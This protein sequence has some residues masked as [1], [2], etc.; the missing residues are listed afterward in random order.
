ME[1]L[2]NIV[3]KNLVKLRQNA[4]LTQLEL[5]NKIQ[6]SDKSVSKWER[7]ES[8]PDLEVLVKLSKIYDVN[9]N[10]FIEKDEKKI[11]PK[12]L[13]KNSHT[14][15][16]LLSAGLVFFIA[17][18]VFAVLFMIPSTKSISWIMFVYATPISAIAL[19]ALSIKWKNYLL[20]AIYTSIILW[21]LIISICISI[22][23]ADIWSLCVIGF[24][25]EFLIIFWFILRKIN[26][27]QK[28]TNIKNSIIKKTDK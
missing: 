10:T 20:Q 17:S 3:S 5:A 14:M 19:L 25:F 13:I 1:E 21:G 11:I 9:L 26:F 18:I 2:R 12:K 6:Y 27:I 7:G 28:L 24:V 22:N 23:Y 8:L 15:I 16:S 4:K